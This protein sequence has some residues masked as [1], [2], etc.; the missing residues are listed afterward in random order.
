MDAFGIQNSSSWREK[1]VELTVKSETGIYTGLPDPEYRGVRVFRNIPYAKAPV[2]KLRWKP[3]VPRQPSRQHHYSHRFPP[4]CPQY[5]SKSLSLWNSNITNFSISPGDQSYHAGEMAQTS[6]EDCLSL[7]IWTPINATSVTKFPVGFFIPGGS[8]RGGG[9]SAPYYNPAGW[10]NRTQ[11]HIMVMINYRVNIFGFPNAAGLKTQNLGILDQRLALEWVYKNIE[12]F[13]G[14][15]NRITLWGHSAG[16]LSADILNFA[17]P[18]DPLA[19]ALFLMSGT[20]MRT[21]A[22]GDNALQTNFSFV[23]RKVGC[24]FPE[25]AG[26][27]LECM[28]QVPATLISNFAG[29]YGDNHTKPSLF[30]RPT[31]DNKIIYENY[32]ERA[33]KGLIS[34][35]PALVSVTSNE[36][37]SLVEY[38][39]NNLIGGPNKTAVDKGT[40]SDFICP[41][42]NT[43]NVRAENNLTTYRYQYVGN[44]SNITP[45]SWMGAYHGADLPMIFGTYNISGGSTEFQKQVAERMQDYVFAFLADPY[46]GLAKLGWAP[47][48]DSKNSDGT[49]VRLGE[50]ESTIKN[51][52][53]IDVDNACMGTGAYDPALGR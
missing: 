2:G 24:E 53:S 49:M 46:R 7:A 6:A 14:D 21:F 33:L 1:G 5:L 15:Q 41:A 27:E 34:R 50:D 51:I 12:D 31:A 4:P 25:D 48:H 42:Y 23:A 43:S 28:Q 32:T 11:Q 35:I 39:V 36:Q 38:P 44:Y 13:G 10:I 47:S 16:A 3:P 40:L 19:A 26:A 29:H 8:F 9:L 45:Y 20:A 22:Q 37:S 52:S 18:H 17:Y 30:F